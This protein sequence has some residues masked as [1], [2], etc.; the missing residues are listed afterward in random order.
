MS[1]RPPVLAAVTSVALAVPM[2]LTAFGAA[3]AAPGDEPPPTGGI[4]VVSG[5]DL[6]RPAGSD[7]EARTRPGSKVAPSLLEATGEVTA[8]VELDAPSALDTA[9]AGGTQAEVAEAAEDVEVLAEEVVADQAAARSAAP[10]PEAVTVTSNLVAGVVVAGDAARIRAMAGDDAVVSVNLIV[11]KTPTNKGNDVFTRALETWTATGRTGEGVRMGIIDTGLDY[12]HAAFGGPG[13]VEAYDEAYGADGT[14]PVPAGLFD[15]TKFLGGHDFAGPT[16]NADDQPVAEPD[17]NPIDAPHTAGGGHGSHVAGTAAGF[18]IGPDGTTFR[19][20]YSSLTDIS[21]WKIGPG[22]APMAGIYALKVFGDNGG[23]TGLVINALEWAADPNGDLDFND[24]LDI[25]NM[26]LGSDTSPADDP[27]NA[28][29]D[30]LTDLGV[31]TVTSAGNAGDITDVGGSPGNSRSALTVANSVSSTQ[32]YDAVEI[33]DA[34]DPAAEGLQPGQYSQNY[35]GGTDVTAPVVFLGDEV[36]GCTDL[37]DRTAE[38]A[39]NIAWLYWDDNDATRDCGS[40][41]R[42]NNA[43]AAGAVGVLF[44]TELPVFSAGIAG[45]AGIPGLQLTGTATD[46]LLP[47]VQAGGVVAHMGPSLA[48]AAFVTEPSLADTLASGSSRGV[49]GSLGIIKPDVAAPG[50]LV[51]SVGSGTGDGSWTISGTSMASPHVAGIAALVSAEHPDWTPQQIKASVMNTATHDVYSELGQTG[52]IFGPERVGS[53]RVDA[54]DA[55]TNDVLAFATE[56]PEL[57]SVTFGLVPVGAETVVEHRTVTVRNTGDTAKTYWTSFAGATTAGG[58]TITTTPRSLTVPA[59]GEGLVTVTLT[60]DPTALAKDLDPTSVPSYDLGGEIPRDYVATLS[61]RLI[62]QPSYGAQLRVPVQAAPRLASDLSTEPVT[63]ADEAT[64]TAPLTLT[65]RGVDSGGYLSLV[66]PFTLMGTSPQLEGDPGTGTSASSLAAADLR[67]VG[68]ASTAPQLVA[69]GADPAVSGHGTLGIGIATEGQWASIGT[70][71]VPIVDT[72][73]DGDGIW[74]LET[75]VTKFSPDVDVTTTETYA[76]EYTEE[77]GYSLGA[78]LDITGANGVFGNLDTTVFDSDVIVVP[79]NL[80]AVGIVEGDTP[81]FSVATF[82]PYAPSPSGI[83]DEVAPFTADPFAPPFWFDAGAASAD[84]LWYVGEPGQVATVHRGADVTDGQLLVLHTHNVDGRR[85]EVVDVTVNQ[86]TPTTTALAV[87][88]TP[89]EG[90]E[91]TL[92]AT[93]SPAEATG[94]VQF[95]DGATELGTAPVSGGTA[96]LTTSLSAGPHALQA[97][98]TPDTAAFT[99]STSEVVNLDVAPRATS[100]ISVIA[101]SS[102]RE[103]NAPVVMALVRSDAGTPSGRVEVRE[104]GTLLGSGRVLAFGR[105]GAAV[106]WLPRDLAVGAHHLTVTYTGN[107][108]VAPSS[109]DH[110]LQVL[111]RRR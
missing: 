14:G 3:A 53:G 58:A 96:R 16:Y 22:T 84:S 13:T 51:S 33:V 85:A 19:G 90:S 77:E 56:D 39:G 1:R 57:V 98:F 27:E 7:D 60:A 49:H 21:D 103:G 82:S 9:E 92:V 25:I 46:L 79:M 59:G 35:A 73:I 10:A 94:T 12:T 111:P 71:V 23:S 108:M 93:V 29:V 41:V 43:Q 62:L 91:H 88:G 74:D 5:R 97:V 102:V 6:V 55:T 36:S 70:N 28:F 63:F 105:T 44:G 15:P 48:N 78:L 18:G 104:N 17:E 67:Y 52:P 100:R 106:M 26:S 20:D 95:L 50:T 87:E 75:Y 45:N 69:A 66:A 80:D 101:P 76:L 2:S 68:F 61:G 99:G 65:G 30:R 109:A 64:T 42:F 8:F 54:L 37:T 11:P 24:H 40:T 72:D 47:Q 38:I 81:T 34:P 110:H 83:V 4:P 107:T 31:L 86:A 89:F 32:T